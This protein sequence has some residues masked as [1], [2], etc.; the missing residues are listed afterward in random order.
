MKV[1]LFNWAIMATNIIA[2]VFNH[3]Q[4]IFTIVVKIG[5]THAVPIKCLVSLSGRF[6]DS[7][8]VSLVLI[9]GQSR[10]EMSYLTA[11]SL[12]HV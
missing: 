6:L 11:C 3:K 7:S 8:T 2:G 10:G 5:Q 12:W 1:A 4:N 9:H